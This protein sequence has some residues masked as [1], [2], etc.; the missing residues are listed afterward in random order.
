MGGRKSYPTRKL[1]GNSKSVRKSISTLT[2]YVDKK[3]VNKVGKGA[4]T[5]FAESKKTIKISAYS[6]K[7][8]PFII[9]NYSKLKTE[10]NE[11]K[12][13]R[14]ISSE[15]SRIKSKNKIKVSKQVDRVI[16]DNAFKAIRGDKK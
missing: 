5:V 8:N 11:N 10:K 13:R 15:W 3:E 12:I 16:V 4:F 14:E 6:T 1:V 7:L 9:R 2:N